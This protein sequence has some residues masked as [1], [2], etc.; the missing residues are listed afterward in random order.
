MPAYPL[1]L[2]RLKGIRNGDIVEV[3]RLERR[4]HALVPGNRLP[5]GYRSSRGTAAAPTE[6]AVLTTSSCTA[7]SAIRARVTLSEST[8]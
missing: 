7:P 3:D 4:F 2:M 8:A 5:A 6:A 1:E